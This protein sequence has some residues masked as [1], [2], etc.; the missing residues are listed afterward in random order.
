MGVFEWAKEKTTTHGKTQ[1]FQLYLSCFHKK[2]SAF[3]NQ[4][5]KQEVINRHLLLAWIPVKIL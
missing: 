5:L 3:R 2:K 1:S 4:I